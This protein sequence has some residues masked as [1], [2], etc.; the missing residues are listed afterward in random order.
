MLLYERKYA[1]CLYWL[2][3]MVNSQL[4]VNT[5]VIICTWNGSSFKEAEFHKVDESSVG[6]M[7]VKPMIDENLAMLELM[8][9]NLQGWW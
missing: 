4:S 8:D 2:L 6:Q 7:Y 5:T 9:E 1:H 3:S